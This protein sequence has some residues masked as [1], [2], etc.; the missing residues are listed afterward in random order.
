MNENKKKRP[1]YSAEFKAEAIA[2]VLSKNKLNG[3]GMN[4]VV[5][6]AMRCCKNSYNLPK[7]LKFWKPNF[8]RP[9]MSKVDWAGYDKALKQRGSITFWVSEEASEA[10]YLSPLAKEKG[11]ESIRTLP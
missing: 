11:K 6:F 10:W 1:T 2:K 9:E 5:P 8:R 3:L 4:C 7:V